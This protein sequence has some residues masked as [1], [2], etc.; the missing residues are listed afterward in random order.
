MD[1]NATGVVRLGARA[2]DFPAAL[3]RS[4]S[5]PFDLYTLTTHRGIFSPTGCLVASMTRRF[6]TVVSEEHG[7]F[8]PAF[9]AIAKNGS[10]LR[11]KSLSQHP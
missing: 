8:F 2:L 9:V 5:A 10:F 7:W 4:Q 6:S 11:L 1:K 3:P